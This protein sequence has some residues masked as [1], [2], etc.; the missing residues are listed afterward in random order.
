[1]ADNT[2]RGSEWRK[3]D[4]HLH[5]PASYYNSY[6]DNWDDFV[7]DVIDAGNK[8]GIQAFATADY[9]TIDGFEKL[10]NYYDKQTQILK[11]QRVQGKQRKILIIPGIELRVKEFAADNASINLHV[12]F[13]PSVSVTFIRQNFLEELKF[14]YQ[15]RS[16]KLSEQNLL[17]AGKS[18][19][20]SFPFNQTEDFDGIS[21]ADKKKYLESAYR[22]ITLEKSDIKSAIQE[23][24]HVL[25]KEHK[26]S[27]MIA[28]A[29]KGHGGIDSL[30]WFDKSG[31]MSR[32]GLMREDFSAD[33]DMFFSCGNTDIDFY[34]GRLTGTDKE[35]IISRFGR[36]KPCIWG[37]DAHQKDKIFHPSNGATK[38]YTWIKSDVTYEGLKQI[39]FEPEHRI[40]IQENNPAEDYPKSYISK[41]EIQSGKILDTTKPKFAQTQLHLNRDMVAVIGGRGSGKSLLIDVLASVF[42]KVTGGDS[43]RLERIN[44]KLD[45]GVDF[46]KSDGEENTYK[47]S[48]T[49]YLDYLHVHQGQVKDMVVDHYLL[50]REIKKLLGIKID[51]DEI[52]LDEKAQNEI[53]RIGTLLEFFE[54]KNQYGTLVNTVEYQKQRKRKYQE[55]IDTITTEENKTKIDK[56]RLNSVKLE[57][58]TNK[59]DDLRVL[60]DDIVE[61]IED[62]ASKI[63]EVNSLDPNVYNDDMNTLL[64]TLDD[65]AAKVVVSEFGVI[66]IEGAALDQEQ[67]ELLDLVN[68]DGEVGMAFRAAEDLKGLIPNVP[69][70]DLTKQSEA[71]ATSI[72]AIEAEVLII[73]TA[74]E[75]IKQEFIDS[76]VGG[77]INK[78]LDSVKQ[79]QDSINTLDKN[80]TTIEVRKKELSKLLLTFGPKAE[81]INTKLIG[82]KSEIDDKWDKVKN[83]EDQTPEQKSLTEKLLAEIEIAG[84]VQFNKRH[85]YESMCKVLNMTRFKPS[86][87]KIIID[88]LEETFGIKDYRDFIEFIKDEKRISID[89]KSVTLSEFLRLSDY[90]VQRGREDMLS[91]IFIE[92][93]YDTY[94]SVVTKSTY[95]GREP[96]NLSVGQRGTFYVCIKLATDSFSTP[97]IFDQP[98]DDLDSDFIVQKLVPIFREIK[99]Y[100]Q[101]I[102]I[103]HNPNFVVNTDVEQV[104]YANNENEILSYETGGIE[105]PEMR[106]HIYEVLEGGMDAFK[107]REE[108]YGF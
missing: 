10:Q 94:L 25:G 96:R 36:L 63:D 58:L 105:N 71:I 79:Y 49:N 85:F 3:W 39:L 103:T 43:A 81:E 48:E 23:V 65:S 5:T 56:Y 32:A 29:V 59:L 75:A 61:D 93:E 73:E 102:I 11:S 13:D 82:L 80:I 19:S 21:P 40:R 30:E 104:I 106:R 7:E 18:I 78:L 77:D 52:S 26:K 87:G 64:A 62:Y 98:D 46:T 20:K 1:M 38:K 6:T 100:R 92:D 74:N 70:I 89:G 95:L 31:A 2:N 28:V 41:I 68:E 8:Y 108:K 54:A 17:A 84:E 47:L 12:F 101:V 90:F 33:A 55:L 83:P 24:N 107:N 72:T 57:A 22:T 86:A 53:S 67:Q 99:N 60:R 42:G 14:A 37:S 50:D 69:D 16:L 97:L 4:L 15:G 34:L 44:K 51:S 9:F 91:L 66:S 35:E 27:V 76:G 88:K 45:F